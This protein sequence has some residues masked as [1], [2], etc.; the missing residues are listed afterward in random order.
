VQSTPAA[1]GDAHHGEG[2]AHLQPPS[3]SAAVLCVLPCL[4]ACQPAACSTFLLL[5]LWLPLL[6]LQQL[7]LTSGWAGS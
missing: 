2:S 7:L 4:R 6:L 5:L 1:G 3:W